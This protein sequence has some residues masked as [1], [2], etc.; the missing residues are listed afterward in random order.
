MKTR[1]KTFLTAIAAGAGLLLGAHAASAQPSPP[2][3]T[4][5]QIK[6]IVAS[7]DRSAADRTNDQRR[8]PEQMLVFIGIRPG[9]TALDL[10][11]AGGYTT[12]LLARA[13][14][15]VGHRLRPEPAARSQPGAHA[16]GRPRGQQQSDRP[17]R[18]GSCGDAGRPGWRAAPVARRPGRPR[19]RSPKRRHQ[20]RADHRRRPAVRELPFRPNSRSSIS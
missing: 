17:V 7:P 3:L 20:G 12:E 9:I 18:C 4:Q 6:Q 8:K 16:A 19:Q 15:P 5:E 14:G 1:R 2:P 13:I 10:S 11:A